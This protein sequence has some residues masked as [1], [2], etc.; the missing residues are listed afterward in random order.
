MLFC[1]AKGLTPLFAACKEGNAAQVT[2]LIEDGAPAHAEGCLQIA[3]MNKH[4]QIVK[5]LGNSGCTNI[6][7]VR[8]K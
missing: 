5:I 4:Y 8:Y 1:G 2:K 3:M 7:Q 6:N